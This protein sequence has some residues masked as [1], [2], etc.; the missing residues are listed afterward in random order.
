ME[1]TTDNP[2]TPAVVEPTQVIPA[3]R[4]SDTTKMVTRMI[5]TVYSDS[6]YPSTVTPEQKRHIRT[7]FV[8]SVLTKL[9]V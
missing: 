6:I 1:D 9:G 7:S 2:S 4:V 5:D 8:A 3:A